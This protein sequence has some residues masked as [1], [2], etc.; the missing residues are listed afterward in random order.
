MLPLLKRIDKM[1]YYSEMD[2]IQALE[3]DVGIIRRRKPENKP[4]SICADCPKESNC[5]M[6]NGVRQAC[7]HK[8]IFTQDL[9]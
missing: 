8:H 7:N 4:V 2:D 6:N 5:H 1:S 9:V 3:D